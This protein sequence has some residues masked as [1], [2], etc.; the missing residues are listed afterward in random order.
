MNLKLVA[1]DCALFVSLFVLPGCG[2]GH[3]SSSTMAPPTITT[4]P[5]SA[6]VTAGQAVSFS[7]AAN[8][9]SPLAYQW[10]KNG[11]AISGATSASYSIPATVAS[12]DGASFRVV[13]SNPVGSVTSNSPHSPSACRWLR[14]QSRNNLQMR[15]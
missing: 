10:Q 15:R 7:V 11:S 4:Q 14:H 12:D 6:S 5:S 9:G 3:F 1:I 8:G 13:V 2:G